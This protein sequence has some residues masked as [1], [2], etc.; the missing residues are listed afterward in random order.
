M[1]S[2]GS[3]T[4]DTTFHP[5]VLYKDVQAVAIKLGDT[6]EMVEINPEFGPVCLHLDGLPSSQHVFFDDHTYTLCP[7]KHWSQMTSTEQTVMLHQIAKKNRFVREYSQEMGLSP[8]FRNGGRT[9]IDDSAEKF[10]K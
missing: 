2:T 8:S 10:K 5:P 9:A 1:A 3:I 6:E 4:G 7:T